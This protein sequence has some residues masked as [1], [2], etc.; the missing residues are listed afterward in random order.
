MQAAEAQGAAQLDD[1]LLAVPRALQPACA[2]MSG[3]GSDGNGDDEEQRRNVGAIVGSAVAATLVAALLCVTAALLLRRRRRK[4]RAGRGGAH[5]AGS[6]QASGGGSFG[7]SPSTTESGASKTQR[8]MP[9]GGKATHV[10]SAGSAGT[11][12]TSQVW[13]PARDAPAHNNGR[14]TALHCLFLTS[15]CAAAPRALPPLRPHNPRGCSD[16]GKPPAVPPAEANVRQRPLQGPGTIIQGSSVLPVGSSSHAT[17]D[18]SA[19]AQQLDAALDNMRR[20]DELFAGQYVVRGVASGRGGQSYVRVRRPLL[21]RDRCCPW[22]AM[23]PSAGVRRPRNTA[24]PCHVL[25]CAA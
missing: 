9:S 19:V 8:S 14:T 17:F 7:R 3:A 21:L 16:R 23:S 18:A 12:A 2:G 6:A 22:L 13:G 25:R 4:R 10:T 5:G 1:A 20:R 15:V 24:A 11:F